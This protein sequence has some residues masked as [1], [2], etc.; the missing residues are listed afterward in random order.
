MSKKKNNNSVIFITAV[1][2]SQ[3]IFILSIRLD[4]NEGSFFVLSFAY[5]H[6]IVV[7]DNCFLPRLKTKK[8]VIFHWL[9]VQRLRHGDVTTSL[10]LRRVISI[11]WC[12]DQEWEKPD[13]N[14]NFS[15]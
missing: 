1:A 14:R 12:H 5:S 13:R 3:T 11:T 6:W 4:S 7:L 15:R 8:E 2:P 10:F 9:V